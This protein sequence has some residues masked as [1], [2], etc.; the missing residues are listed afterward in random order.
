MGSFFVAKAHPVTTLSA[1]VGF[2][3][4]AA[5]LRC[6]PI[7]RIGDRIC[8]LETVERDELVRPKLLAQFGT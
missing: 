2:M 1:C 3:Q 8:N 7:A 5:I 6:D 4:A